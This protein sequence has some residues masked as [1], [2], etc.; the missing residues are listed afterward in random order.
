MHT[1]TANLVV[2][3]NLGGGGTGACVLMQVQDS[4]V[5]FTNGWTVPSDRLWNALLGH[6]GHLGKDT[7]S[8]QY[9]LGYPGSWTLMWLQLTACR[10]GF[11]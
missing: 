3:V 10:S 7:A 1:A 4:A 8:K 6:L 9:N 11:V 2:M 5:V